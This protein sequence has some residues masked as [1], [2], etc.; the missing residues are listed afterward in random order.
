MYIPFG[1]ISTFTSIHSIIHNKYVIA[2]FTPK[3]RSNKL[4]LIILPVVI[5]IY[6]VGRNCPNYSG[7]CPPVVLEFFYAACRYCPIHWS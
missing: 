5:V 4:I 3:F 7:C 2:T 6:D 1:K